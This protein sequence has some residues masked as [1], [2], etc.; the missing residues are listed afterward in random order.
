MKTFKSL[1]D[2]Q[3]IMDVSPVDALQNFSVDKT[4]QNYNRKQNELYHRLIYGYNLY[5]KEQLYA[6][7]STKKHRIKRNFIK[8][9]SIINIM[10]QEILI[11]KT[12]A[13]FK[14]IYNNNNKKDNILTNIIKENKP[15][16]KFI[17]TLSFK[18][19]GITKQ[20][21]IT[22]FIKEKI[23]PLNYYSMS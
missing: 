6:M 14:F 15:D 18:D 8:A 16:P 2:L 21:I 10:K 12:N 11:E 9:Q 23:L 7:N 19:L 1:K 4:N 13:M 5:T 3:S 17:C 22:R 20:D